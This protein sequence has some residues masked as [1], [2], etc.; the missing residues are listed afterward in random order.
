MINTFDIESVLTD[1]SYRCTPAKYDPAVLLFEDDSI[2]GFVVFFETVEELLSQ[3]KEKQGQFISRMAVEL[4]RSS[5]KSWNCYAI[6]LT[7][8]KVPIGFAPRL[9]DLEEDLSLTRKLVGD[10]VSSVGAIFR[11]LMP[12]LPLQQKPSINSVEQVPLSSR[13]PTWNE[14]ARKLLEGSGSGTDILEALL[15]VQ[16]W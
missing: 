2:M 11:V 7:R 16:T 9:S 15:E 10:D 3:W 14:N 1:A 13:L 4:R 5:R 8:E 6:F 12:I